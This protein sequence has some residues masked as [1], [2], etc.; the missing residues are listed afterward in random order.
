[1]PSVVLFFDATRKP[2]YYVLKVIFPLIL[3]V[4]MSWTVFWIAPSESGTQ[5]SVAVTSIL[6]LIAYRF[7]QEA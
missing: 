7:L 1:M 6:T 4:I 5:I 3:I 2:G